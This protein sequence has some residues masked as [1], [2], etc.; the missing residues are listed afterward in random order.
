MSWWSYVGMENLPKPL[1]QVTGQKCQICGDDVGVTVDGEL[2]VAC[3]EC[4][5]PV[6]R[7][8]YEYERQEGSQIC[9][10]CKTRFKRLKGCARVEGDEEEDDIDDVENE[11]NFEGR[12]RDSAKLLDSQQHSLARSEAMLHGHS[13]G[14]HMSYGHIFDSSELHP[15]TCSVCVCRWMM[16]FLLNNMHW[17]HRQWVLVV[18]AAAA[19]EGF[20]HFLS[21]ILAYPCNLDPW[22]LPRIWLLM[23]M[24]A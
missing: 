13:G 18:A 22:I 4:A 14:S 21:Q 6:C 15:H 19:A 23:A 7:T 20:I 8:C 11:F 16:I 2:F 24:A 12:V 3:N 1:K 5:F 17:F 9:P 10:Q